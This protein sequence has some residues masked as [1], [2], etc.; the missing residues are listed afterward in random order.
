MLQYWLDSTPDASWNDIIIALSSIGHHT[1]TARLR[2]KYIVK[3]TGQQ[4]SST[5]PV[6]TGLAI[7]ATT[8]GKLKCACYQPI[9]IAHAS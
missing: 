3:I 2:E 6:D 4:G 7:T 8:S 9:S 5:L 1:L